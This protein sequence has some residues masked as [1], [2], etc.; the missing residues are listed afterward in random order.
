MEQK[1][2]LKQKAVSG[3]FW[4]FCQ[5]AL[6]QII[7]FAISVVLARLLM[8]EEFGLVALASM[9]T[10]LFAIFVDCGF[11]SA[12]IQKKNVDE[13]DYNTIF[14][15]QF[16]FS[17]I[18]YLII[19]I[20]SP[21]LAK[22]FQMPTLTHV[23][24]VLALGMILGSIQS[25]QGVIVT[26]K[27]AFKTYF[28]ATM[29]GSILSGCIGV[30][31]A[32]RGW[33]VWALVT[34]HLSSTVLNT[35]TVFVQVRWIPRFMFS[36]SRFK[37]LIGISSKYM[38]SSIIGTAFSQ[39]RGYTI[40]LKYTAADLAYYNRGEGVPKIFINNIDSSINTV[41]FPVFAKIQDDRLAVKNALRRSIKMSSFL[42]FPMLLGLAAIA[43]NLVFLLYTEKWVKC[44]PFMQLFCV[45]ECFTILNTANLQALKGIGK[46]NTILKLEVYKKPVMIAILVFT[47]YI[48]PLAIAAGMCIYGIYTMIINALPNRKYID[49]HI[50]EQLKDVSEN[51]ILAIVMAIIVY[52]IGRIEMNLHA[53]ILIQVLTGCVCYI[54]CAEFLHIESWQYVKKSIQPY[55]Q[56]FNNSDRQL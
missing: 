31:L 46:I 19:F 35:L 6:S 32:Y 14:W 52:A 2:E 10:L 56:K 12:L 36:F 39:L 45:S 55:L 26:R 49:Y 37:Y 8:P 54:G 48:S 5:K 44:I 23:I 7:S 42:I 9:L 33:G 41:L 16:L 3:L 51:A 43:D 13:L 1:T 34:Q 40:G 28:Y 29:I 25:I 24:R 53:T 27:M 38:L 22:L 4:Q 15:T 20:F 17:T 47:M 50:I 30:Y 18:I 11:G 21:W